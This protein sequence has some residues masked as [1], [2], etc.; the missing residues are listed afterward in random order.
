MKVNNY[1]SFL[2]LNKYIYFDFLFLNHL[3]FVLNIFSGHLFRERAEIFITL[4]F[5]ELSGW[6]AKNLI[7]HHPGLITRHQEISIFNRILFVLFITDEG[8]RRLFTLVK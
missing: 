6:Q 8:M 3:N 2:I 4:S 5:G 1:C 7:S